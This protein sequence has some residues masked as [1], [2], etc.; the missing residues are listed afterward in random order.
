YITVL[1]YRVILLF[2]IYVNVLTLI[3]M[4]SLSFQSKWLAHREEVSISTDES[5][6]GLLILYEPSSRQVAHHDAKKYYLRCHL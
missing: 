2:L 4:F 5:C 3:D 1:H 6:H